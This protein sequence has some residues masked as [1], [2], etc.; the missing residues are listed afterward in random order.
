MGCC[1]ASQVGHVLP[2]S[3]LPIITITPVLSEED[4]PLTAASKLL[5][6]HA[7]HLHFPGTVVVI[8]SHFV[9]FVLVL[10]LWD[11]ARDRRS[12]GP[13][14]VSVPTGGQIIG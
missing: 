9:V 8:G 13:T 3:H 14:A 7:A 10:R 12:F 4:A 6:S 2:S 1:S 11:F 5:R